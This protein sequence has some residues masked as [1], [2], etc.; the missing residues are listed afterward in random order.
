MAVRWKGMVDDEPP[1]EYIRKCPRCGATMQ[2]GFIIALVSHLEWMPPKWGPDGPVFS[3]LHAFKT[4]TS[5]VYPWK[6][7][8]GNT[9]IPL[10]YR[11]T[12]CWIYWLGPDDHDRPQPDPKG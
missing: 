3:E 6:W 2:V 5:P 12:A 8:H 7:P 10:S 1:A 4:G 9:N 11:C